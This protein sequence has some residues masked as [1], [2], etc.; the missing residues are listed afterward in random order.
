MVAPKE[1]IEKILGNL[2]IKRDDTIVVYDEGI[3]IYAGRLYWVLKYYGHRDVRFLEGGKKLLEANK[4]ELSDEQPEV[5]VGDYIIDSGN[6]QYRVTMDFVLDN[7]KNPDIVLVDVRS[8]EEYE[9]IDVRANRGGHI[10]GAVNVNWKGTVN[11]DGTIKTAEEL[12]KLYE[13][14]GVT[15]DKKIITYCSSGVRG[16][17]SWFVVKAL[18]G[19]PD[20]TLYDG[21]WEEWGNDPDVPAV[22]GK[23]PGP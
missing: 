16:A 7:L 8:P 15:P 17:Y 18:L 9:G 20:V 12:R 22:T 10:P 1:Q 3:S 21:S 2:G 19:Y 11:P 14:K 5:I 23:E 6:P 13:S 4:F